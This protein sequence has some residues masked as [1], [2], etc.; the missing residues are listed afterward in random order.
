VFAFVF[1]TIDEPARAVGA[2]LAKI[3]EAV[4]VVCL[5]GRQGLLAEIRCRDNAHLVAVFDQIR[6]LDGVVDVDSLTAMEYRKSATSGIAEEI[7][8]TPVAMRIAKPVPV[9][10]KLDEVDLTLIGELVHNGRATFVDLAPKS[11]LSQAG[12]RARVQ[13][14]LEEQIIVIQAFPSAEALGLAYF[15]AVQVSVRGPVE[16]VAQKLCA[17]P[18]F[19]VVALSGGAYDLV[20]EVWCR[21]HPHLLEILDSVRSIANVGVVQSNTYLEILKEDYRLG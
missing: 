15:A 5:A 13:R 14:L 8:G 16:P 2:E 19:I 21:N 12:V 7:L 6:G 18:E 17:M 11:G 10:R 3:P 20:C 1:L 9:R 4:F